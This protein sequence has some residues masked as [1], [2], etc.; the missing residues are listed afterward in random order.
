MFLNYS[1]YRP[2]NTSTV[3]PAERRPAARGAGRGV[4]GYSALILT[5]ICKSAR[6]LNWASPSQLLLGCVDTA[7]LAQNALVAA[8]S[9]GLGGVYIGGL[10]NNIDAV[11]EL[12]KLPQHVLP[13]F[14][15]CL[16]WPDDNPEVKP[17]MPSAMLVH[18]NH[19]QPLDETVLAEYDEQIAQYYL[20]RGSNTRRDTWSDHI[21]RTIVKESRPFILEYLHKQ[22][23]ATR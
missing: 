19:Y 13:L 8:E 12:L 2:G 15:L 17:R 6:T 18:E 10:R 23:W 16:G 11:T 22:G 20:S 21:R 3:G 9:L 5:A 14:G 7:L 4:F 1:R